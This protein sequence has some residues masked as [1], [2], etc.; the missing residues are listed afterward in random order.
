MFMILNFVAHQ[1]AVLLVYLFHCILD[2]DLDLT[3]DIEL[4][5]VHITEVLLELC[6]FMM[7][8]VTQP[9]RTLSAG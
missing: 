6:L 9:L 2:L 3:A 4:S 5:L 7:S 1:T 8:L